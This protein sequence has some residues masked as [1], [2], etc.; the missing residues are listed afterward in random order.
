MLRTLVT[1]F[2]VFCA[3]NAYA[4]SGSQGAPS[5]SITFEDLKAKCAELQSNP[6]MKT[7]KVEVTCDE[8]S[9]YWAGGKPTSGLLK[10]QRSIGASLRMKTFEVD[11]HNFPVNTPDTNIQCQTFQKIERKV[12]GVK[13]ELTCDDIQ[14]VNDLATFCEPLVSQRASQD[15]GAVEERATDEVINLCPQANGAG[16][17][18]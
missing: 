9:Y 3:A 8:L 15:P 4:A 2:A 13:T 18:N 17:K 16:S 14:A 12:H 1:G 6:Q 10:N 5:S 11:H 7:I